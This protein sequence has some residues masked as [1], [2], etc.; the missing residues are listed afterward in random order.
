MIALRFV[1]ALVAAAC[2]PLAALGADH[3]NLEE[4]LPTRVED[5]YPL[6]FRDREVQASF[7]YDRRRENKDLFALSPRIEVGALPNLQAAIAV[8][9]LF[10]SAATAGSG[11]VD[12]DVL[13]NF[14]TEPAPA[15]TSSIAS[16]STSLGRR[17]PPRRGRYEAVLG[18]QVRAGPRSDLPRQPA[19]M[20][21]QKPSFRLTSL[22]GTDT[23]PFA[24][25]FQASRYC[26][27]ATSSAPWLSR[28]AASAGLENGVC[29][30]S[31][32]GVKK[33]PR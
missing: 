26:V 6:P 3:L 28:Y 9:F 7:R 5:A 1:R 33:L 8:P 11:D 10:G 25:S 17:T 29:R 32:N 4:G 13:Y 23:M 22:L 31:R 16:I 2:A 14:N 19:Q 21:A 12:L 15:S 20:S 27:G 18:Y 30:P 24:S